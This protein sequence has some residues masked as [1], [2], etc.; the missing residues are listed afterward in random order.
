MTA[1]AMRASTSAPKKSGSDARFM[2]IACTTAIAHILRIRGIHRKAGRRED[3]LG[4]LSER[5][6]FE[7]PKPS[8]LP[9][10]LLLFP[11]IAKWRVG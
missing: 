8:R 6:G 11:K 10:F 1:G 3:F 5:F 4:V 2:C 7:N 9:A